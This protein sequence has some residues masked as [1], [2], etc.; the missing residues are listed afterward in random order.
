MPN[1]ITFTQFAIDR[2]RPP[3]EGRETYWDKLTPGFGL[4]VSAP[5]PGSAATGRKTWIAM[6]RVDGKPVMTT[7]GTLAQIPKVDKARQAAREAILQMK[8][9]TSPVAERRAA[10]AQRRVEAEQAE[11]AAREAVEGR[12]DVVARR[13]LAEHIDRRC[14]AKYAA[15]CRRI[16]EHDVLPRW[17]ERPIREITKHDVNE[18][19]DAKASLREKRRKG[20]NGGA[21]IQSNRTLARLRT[22]FA[23]SA[24]EDFVDA[25]PTAGVLA[26][27]KERARDR[28]LDDDEIIWF[29]RGADAAGWPFGP[30]FKLLLLTAQRESEVAGMRWSEVDLVEKRTWTLPRERTKSDRAHVVHLSAFACE[31]LGGLPRLGELVFSTTGQTPVSGFGAVKRRLDALMTAQA[32]L[33]DAGAS[34]PSWVIHD[35]RRTATTILARLKVPPHIADKVLNHSG[36]TIRGVAAVYN[37]YEYLDE[38]KAALEALGRFIE[39]LVRPAPTN[40]VPIRA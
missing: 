14:S 3:A 39:S 12:F 34:L 20:T 25:N 4:R 33:G 28:V 37:R 35:L 19:L 8:G 7:L 23:W 10:A 2:L 15:E 36:G 21:S 27:G 30:V 29:W 22:F 40:V 9:G 38:R 24:A 6:G 18:L 26:R 17:G 13:F 1:R 16:F 32:Q 11:E 31:I 5:R